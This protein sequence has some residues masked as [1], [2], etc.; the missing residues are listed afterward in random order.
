MPA[1]PAAAV[2]LTASL[3]SLGHHVLPAWPACGCWGDLSGPENQDSLGV[4]GVSN[5]ATSE[6]VS[7]IWC[8]RCPPDIA[9]GLIII[10]G[11]PGWDHH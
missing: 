3:H 5:T 9:V 10:L 4:E 8:P 2:A 6:P 7:S 1:A 11:S